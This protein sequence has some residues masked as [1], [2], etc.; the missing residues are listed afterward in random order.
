MTNAD[1][2]ST[3]PVPP[4]ASP[5]SPPPAAP[6]HPSAPPAYGSA[7]TAQPNPYAVN[8]GPVAPRGLSIASMV[9]GIAS[10]V[11]AFFWFGFLPGVAAV[12]LGHLAQRR[13]PD[14]RPFWLTGII[15]GY[16]GILIGIIQGAFILFLI[17]AAVNSGNGYGDFS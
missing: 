8:A 15:T 2:E 10:V 12:I 7:P 3:P 1:D 11:F 5:Y 6:A 13:Q 14:A 9:T 16:V 17:I 4:A